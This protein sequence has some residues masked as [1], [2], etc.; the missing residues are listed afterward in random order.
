MTYSRNSRNSR[1]FN[2]MVENYNCCLICVTV[3]CASGDS[4]EMFQCADLSLCVPVSWRC[5]G[6]DDCDDKSDESSCPR[7]DEE[8]G[9]CY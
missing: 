9:M 1:Q 5:D 4:S 2:K 8:P 7:W 3:S 6:T